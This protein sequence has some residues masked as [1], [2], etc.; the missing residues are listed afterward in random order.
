[1]A[2]DEYVAYSAVVGPF[3]V[4]LSAA[5]N[6]TMEVRWY[7]PRTSKFQESTQ[8]PCFYLSGTPSSSYTS[9]ALLK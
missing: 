7:N 3:T 6:A 5:A 1:M 2:G 8:H 9:R 4:D